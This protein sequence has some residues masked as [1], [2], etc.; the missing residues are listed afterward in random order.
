M[1][2]RYYG[3]KDVVEKNKYLMCISCT[4]YLFSFVLY[5]AL[6]TDLFMDRATFKVNY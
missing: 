2:D 5:I 4:F 6:I 3:K 1:I